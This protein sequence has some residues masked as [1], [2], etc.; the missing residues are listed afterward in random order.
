MYV[1]T[2]VLTYIRAIILCV[3]ANAERDLLSCTVYSC[4]LKTLL[5][6]DL[7]FCVLFTSF[8][9]LWV[10]TDFSASTYDG[11]VHVHSMYICMYVYVCMYMYVCMYVCMYVH[12]YVCTYVCTVYALIF[13][14]SNY[15]SWTPK[16]M[17]NILIDDEIACVLILHRR[18]QLFVTQAGRLRSA[19]CCAIDIMQKPLFLRF[20]SSFLFRSSNR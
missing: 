1:R 9:F 11:I 20:Y 17:K 14:H 6:A 3:L 8:Q 10:H 2:Y 5:P 15:S 13:R 18:P 19:I 4:V 12:L 16:G 7:W